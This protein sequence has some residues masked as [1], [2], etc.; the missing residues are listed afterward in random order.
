MTTVSVCLSFYTFSAIARRSKHRSRLPR[1]RLTR[2]PNDVGNGWS[3]GT[4]NIMKLSIILKQQA[5]CIKYPNTPEWCCLLLCTFSV[6]TRTS[7][8]HIAT[9]Y[10]MT[11]SFLLPGIALSFAASLHS[12]LRGADERFICERARERMREYLHQWKLIRMWRCG[13]VAPLLTF[14]LTFCRQICSRESERERVSAGE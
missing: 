8:H 13:A 4:T 12:L 6:P 9:V 5:S 1:L 7:V 2:N 10:V 14:H 11:F 3:I